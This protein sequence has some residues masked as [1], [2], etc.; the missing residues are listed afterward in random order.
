MNGMWCNV[1][2][3]VVCFVLGQR[4]HASWDVTLENMKAVVRSEWEEYGSEV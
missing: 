2:H 4:K 3:C 1:K